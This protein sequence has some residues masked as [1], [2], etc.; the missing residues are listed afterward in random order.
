MEI[1]FFQWDRDMDSISIVYL[2]CTILSGIILLVSSN[3]S[4]GF[5]IG[6]AV[7]FV[8]LGLFLSR[9]PSE[10]GFADKKVKTKE[11]QIAFL[12]QKYSVASNSRRALSDYLGQQTTPAEIPEEEQMLINFYVLGCR[13]TGYLGPMN[14]G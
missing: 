13:L 11:D 7:F 5:G 14:N 3:K 2:I 12:S 1:N 8:F 4:Y 10:E 9:N 6:I